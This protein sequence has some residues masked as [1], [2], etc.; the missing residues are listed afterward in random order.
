VSKKR[1]AVEAS[2]QKAIDLAESLA[3]RFCPNGRGGGRDS[4]CSRG[5]DTRVGSL[6]NVD[7]RVRENIRRLQESLR[8]GFDAMPVSGPGKQ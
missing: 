2:L 1:Q 3:K 4:S 6:S 8:E 7:R 5:S